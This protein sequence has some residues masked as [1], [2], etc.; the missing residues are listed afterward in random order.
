MGSTESLTVS[1]SH[2][3]IGHSAKIGSRPLIDYTATTGCVSSIAT[4]VVS[5][6]RE[7]DLTVVAVN[8]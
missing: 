5:K 8:E 2:Q 4:A 3:L 1:I 6:Y 7:N